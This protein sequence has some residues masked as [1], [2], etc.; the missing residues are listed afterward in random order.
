M[1]ALGPGLRHNE[2][3]LPTVEMRKMLERRGVHVSVDA[4]QELAKQAKV[5]VTT[6]NAALLGRSIPYEHFRKLADLFNLHQP[7][8]GARR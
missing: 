4:K 2:G 7:R 6:L 1:L 8:L 5:S 3:V